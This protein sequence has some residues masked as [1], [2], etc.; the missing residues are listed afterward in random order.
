MTTYWKS[1]ILFGINHNTGIK[2]EFDSEPVYN[3]NHLKT[4]IKSYGDEAIAFHD[5]ESP[6]LG[7]SHT[8]SA[9]TA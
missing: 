1:I 9:V 2:K 3:K 8:C 6:K 5:K 7:S 4:N